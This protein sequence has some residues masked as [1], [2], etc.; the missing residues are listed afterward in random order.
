M[1]AAAKLPPTA[2]GFANADDAAIEQIKR[3]NDEFV[4]FHRAHVAALERGDYVTAHEIL[5]DI[6]LLLYREERRNERTMPAQDRADGGM[7]Y[8]ES[9]LRSTDLLDTYPGDMPKA[10]DEALLKII[11]DR[12]VTP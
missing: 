5:R 9:P 8:I 11:R 1:Q 10:L 4:R 2:Q 3:T 6:H 7:E 12:L